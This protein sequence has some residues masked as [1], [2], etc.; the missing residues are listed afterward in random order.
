VVRVPSILAEEDLALHLLDDYGVVVHP[1]Y[2]FDFPSGSYVVVSLLPE[3]DEFA[4]GVEALEK[5]TLS[6]SG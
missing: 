6:F 5:V 3:P 1:G 2:F 4:R